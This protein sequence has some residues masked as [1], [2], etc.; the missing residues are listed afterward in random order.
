M[1]REMLPAQAGHEALHWPR[2]SAWGE[3][4]GREAGSLA[5]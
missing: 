4:G 2:W 5:G 1:S 3:G